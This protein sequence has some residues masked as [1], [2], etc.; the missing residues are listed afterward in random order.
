[1]ASRRLPEAADQNVGLSALSALKG[2][3]SEEELS[4]WPCSC[5]LRIDGPPDQISLFY[6]SFRTLTNWPGEIEYRPSET[7]FIAFVRT[8]WPA[9]R[10]ACALLAQEYSEL[11]IRLSYSDSAGR[12]LGRIELL[13][14]ETLFE[15]GRVWP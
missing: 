2:R 15:E 14:G 4:K 10:N 5:F 7:S 1:M 11:H 6:E 3:V 8:A 9:P 12:V 13:H